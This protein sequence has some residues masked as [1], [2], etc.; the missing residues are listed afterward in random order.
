MC[1]SAALLLRCGSS[2]TEVPVGPGFDAGSLVPP[3]GGFVVFDA[4]PPSAAACDD[5]TTCL[6]GV[7]VPGVFVDQPVELRATLY[8]GFPVNVGSGIASQ[9]VALDTTWA[10][11]GLEAGT[12]YFV[13]FDPG[14]LST[15][16]S[17]EEAGLPT[18]TGPWVVPS[19]AGAGISVRAN[20]AAITVFEQGAVGGAMHLDA[21]LARVDEPLPGASSVSVGVGDASVPLAFDTAQLGYLHQFASP[22]DAQPTYTIVSS[23]PDASVSVAWTLASSPPTT[24]GTITAPALGATV[25]ANQDLPVIWTAGAEADYVSVT[26]FASVDGGYTQV[27]SAP[28]VSIDTT[29]V[30]I[31]AAQIPAGSYLLNVGFVRAYCPAERDG[32]VHS[33]RVV[34]QPVAAQ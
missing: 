9:K 21:V 32:C 11:D 19:E 5:A 8:Q 18:V 7:A 12:H 26:L 31:P 20:P 29:I 14:Y 17:A 6:S 1:A 15:M 27:F 3:D 2:Q 25:P 23:A 4:P 13:Q 22:P 10:F 30:S 34:S 24:A 16:T 28:S 33:S